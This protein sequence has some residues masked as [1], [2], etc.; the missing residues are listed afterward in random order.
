MALNK[1]MHPRNRYKDKPPDFAYLASKYQDF[2]QHVHTSLTG[3]PM[4]VP[5]KHHVRVLMCSL[6]ISITLITFNRGR[7]LKW[8][9]GGSWSSSNTLSVAQ[10]PLYLIRFVLI[11]TEEICLGCMITCFLLACIPL[12]WFYQTIESNNNRCEMD[13]YTQM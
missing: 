2:Q 13:Y 5:D 11:L 1:S 3:R 12:T 9:C 4:W 10:L 7:Y 6:V 8:V